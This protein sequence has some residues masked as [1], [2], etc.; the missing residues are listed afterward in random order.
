MNATMPSE[1]HAHP[2]PRIG[3]VT[4]SY[5]SDDVLPGLLATLPDAV[6]EPYAL[7]IADNRPGDGGA[8][9]IA[10]EAGARYV[11][12]PGNP[13]YGGGMNAGAA[14]LPSSVK[15]VLIVNPDVELR[16]GAVA[17]LV[18][19]GE[20]DPRIASVGPLIRTVEGG[21]YPSARAIPGIRTG[22]GH[23]LLG[24]VWPTNPWTR[25]YRNDDETSP[26]LRDSGWLSGSCQLVRRSAFDELHGFDDAYFMYFEDV[27]L[28]YRF[29]QAG[30]RNVYEPAAEVVHSGAHSTQ[31]DSGRM[32]AAHH[33][34]A[35]RFLQRKYP[36]PILWPVRFALSLG[37]RVRSALAIR[38]IQRFER[39]TE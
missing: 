22:I 36:G 19:R 17:A 10:A 32:I 34:S 18:Q 25:G 2:A 5:G 26:V 20:T 21:V 35:R 13:G 37:L 16:A 8:A 7:V 31:R 4:V 12:L 24:R 27:D 39:V 11:P 1:S 15:W 29:R 28:G 30:Y 6:G 14:F 3:I 38:R 9:A 33:D 23:A